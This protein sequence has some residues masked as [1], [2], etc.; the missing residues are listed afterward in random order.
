MPHNQLLTRTDKSLP[1]RQLARSLVQVAVARGADENKLLRG[2]GIFSEDLVT[3]K[4]LSCIQLQRLAVNAAQHS[5]GFDLA[6]QF[7]HHLVSAFVNDALPYFTHARDF[8]ECLRG[9]ASFQTRL[10]PFVS[11]YRYEDGDDVLLVLQDAMGSGKQFRFMAEA[12]CAALVALARHCTGKR[13]AFHFTFPFARPRHIQEYEEG[14]GFRI[15]FDQPFFTI[16]VSRQALKTPCIQHNRAFKQFALQRFLEQREYRLTL[17]DAV[18]FHLRRS[19][20]STLPD[21]ARVLGLSPAS[22]KRKLAEHDTTFSLLH[23]DI[24]RQQA[25]YYLQVQ[26][27]NNEQSALKMAFSDL[28]NFRRAVKRWTGL[29]PSQL[30][31]A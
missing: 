7:G 28:T 8:A 5:K 14:L 21:I 4:A 1:A 24:R 3:A 13:L 23:D 25:I 12:Y 11:A 18:R 27:L 30:R 17:L 16:R 10:C 19:A 15:A 6:F 9:L 22:L 31:E 29:T 20:S 2:T 26:K